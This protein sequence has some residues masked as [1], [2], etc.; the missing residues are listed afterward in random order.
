MDLLIKDSGDQESFRIKMF[1]DNVAWPM[2][3]EVWYTINAERVTIQS[4][5]LT[6]IGLEEEFTE[7]IRE[8]LTCNFKRDC[9]RFASKVVVSGRCVYC[10]CSAFESQVP[11]LR[12]DESGLIYPIS[13]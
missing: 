12:G 11:Y 13:E 2:S 5:I 10:D 4:Q 3:R 6:T 8:C 9:D 1:R 7:R